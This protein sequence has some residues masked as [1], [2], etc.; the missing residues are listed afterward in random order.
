[1]HEGKSDWVVDQKK[2]YLFFSDLALI[3]V[4]SYTAEECFL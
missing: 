3:A 2:L 4:V 1:M